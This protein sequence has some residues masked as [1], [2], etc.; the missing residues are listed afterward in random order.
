MG[1]RQFDR[2]RPDIA[3]AL[4]MGWVYAKHSSKG[5]LVFHHPHG[6]QHLILSATLGGGRGERNGIAWI[7]KNT[8]REATA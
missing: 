1:R 4:E 5:H 8:P 7:R 6:G 2:K 3:L